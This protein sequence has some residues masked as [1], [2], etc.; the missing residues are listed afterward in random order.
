MDGDQNYRLFHCPAGTEFV[1]WQAG[2][3]PI[4]IT[5]P[6]GG[7][8]RPEFMPNRTSGCIEEDEWT[9]ELAHDI[10]QRWPALCD[11]RIPVV[12]LIP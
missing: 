5:V 4:I 3:I 1:H 6:H 9:V 8:L 11:Q 12:R 10:Y 2:T 7:S